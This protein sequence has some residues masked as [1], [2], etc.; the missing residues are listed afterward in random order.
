MVGMFEF[1]PLS[2]EDHLEV[3][4]WLFP[5]FRRQ[6]ILSRVFPHMI[7]YAEKK[8][9]KSRLI[10]MNSIENKPAQGLLTSLEMIKEPY[11]TEEKLGDG[12][13][14]R[15]LTYWLPLGYQ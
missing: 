15:Q 12:S 2:E 4:F 8:F 7:E 1:H 10:A 9:S 13:I 14:E 3:G 11:V 6:Q 5:E